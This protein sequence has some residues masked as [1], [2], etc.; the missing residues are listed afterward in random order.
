MTRVVVS[1][2]GF[3]TSIGNS[4]AEV[5][6]S[7]RT[8]RNG[9]EV[10]R[11]FEATKE[12]IRL[13][14]TI[15]GFEF[16]SKDFEDWTYPARHRIPR[17]TLRPMSPNGL[18]SYFAL[19]EAIADAGL[20]PELVSSE[21]TGLMCASGGS[22]WLAHENFVTMLSRGVMRCPPMGI[23]NGIPGSLYINLV[24]TFKIRGAA[25][26]FSSACAS[27]S[28]ALGA[29]FDLIRLGRQDIVFVIGAEDCNRFSILPFAAIRALS[30]QTD[31]ALAPR[32][33]DAK[34]DGFVG[35][36]GSTV[37]V[38]ES[39]AHAEKRGAQNLY[40]EVLGWG[41]ASDGFNVLAPEPAGDG[42]ARAMQLALGEAGVAPG[43]IDYL[44]AHATATDFGDAAEIA[45]IK[46]V[47]PEG[48]R[49][50]VSST[51][52]LTGHGLSLAGAME[53]AFCCLALKEGF[54]PVS[55]KIT[56]LDP[57]CEGVPIVTAPVERAPKLALNNSSGFGGAN[58]ATVLKAI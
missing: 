22:F 57:I 33:F 31:P 56:Q 13:A 25:L 2:L 47:F 19:H 51:K 38:V 45:A 14:G 5:T 10:F 30:P 37:L 24:P 23:I 15:K 21:R 49:P 9:I 55:A 12:P 42:L 48:Q 16:P 27:S 58:V 39:L 43:E 1:G 6:E 4:R 11:D 20:P 17:E 40:A 36:G 50:L 34:R 54:T 32:A 28:H 44:N 26:G 3:I 29:A 18:Y 53:S 8:T 46:R 7:L 52:S 35:T 41:Q